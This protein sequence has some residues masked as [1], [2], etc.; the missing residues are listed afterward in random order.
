MTPGARLRS[1]RGRASPDPLQPLLSHL[2]TGPLRVWSLVIT[3]FGD[4]ILPR[5]GRVAMATLQELMARLDIGA[6]TLR[7]ALSR[8]AQENWVTRERAGRAAFYRL[9][10]EGERDFDEAAR[11]IYAAGPPGWGGQWTILLTAASSPRERQHWQRLGFGQTHPGTFVRPETELMPPVEPEAD[12]LLF[13]EA[14]LAS[15]L[16][17]DTWPLEEIAA[18][19]ATVAELIAATDA[20]LGEGTPVP[21]DAIAA[22]VLLIHAWRRAVLRDPGLPP[23]LLPSDWPAEPARAALRT[24]YQRL[25]APSEAWLDE[26]A[27][28]S[29]G[30]PAQTDPRIFS[31][32]G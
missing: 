32:F 14:S 30:V 31:R 24:V 13:R 7:T 6:G 11:R 12:A 29:G 5:S 8:L 9:A 17:H 26:A 3:V 15:D 2:H 23:A 1:H 16:P 19:Y 20:A 10:A 18:A 22:R 21:L 25:L 4:A 28:R 27:R